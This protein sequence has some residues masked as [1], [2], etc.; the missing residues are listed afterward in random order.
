LFAGDLGSHSRSVT[1]RVEG[2]RVLVVGGAGSIGSATVHELVAHGPRELHVV[3]VDENGL[4]ELVRSLRSA[5]VVPP[6][7]NL[8]LT[9]M[10]FGSRLM[11]RL[12]REC[13]PY[14]LVLN[15]A[16]LKHV[17]SEKD[18]LSLMRMLD[19]NVLA[20]RRLLGGL[21]DRGTTHYFAVSTDKAANPV[22]LMGASKRA[23]ELIMFDRRL[24][25]NVTSARFANVAFSNG[26]LLDGWLRRLERRQP[27][28]VPIG[29]RRYFVSAEEA[30]QLC[31]LAATVAHDRTIMIPDL[32]PAQHL[33][34]LVE[35]AGETLRALG[36]EPDWCTTEDEARARMAGCA[37]SNR[38]PVL[39]TPLDTTGEKDFEEFIGVADS[40]AWASF[41]HLR[42]LRTRQPSAEILDEFIELV[43]GMLAAE[44]P[45]SSGDLIDCLLLLVPE[46]DHM[47]RDKG[48]DARM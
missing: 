25:L 8:R 39:L 17:R 23:M 30:G 33:R 2:Q 6:R 26:S 46:L 47:R 22:N 44:D 43:T 1:E 16:A 18:V 4:A 35:V 37:G 19:I 24:P 31:L 38:W 15:F 20:A 13:E 28:A 7:T 40:P 21:G 12:L 5:G 29:T 42:T 9:P 32:D 48:L 10:D 41:K 45:V 3:D 14:D 36:L 27:W 34:D 11:Q